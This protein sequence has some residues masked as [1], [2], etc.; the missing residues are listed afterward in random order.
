M[1]PLQ[2]WRASKSATYGFASKSDTHHNTKGHA[3]AC[4]FVLAGVALRNCSAPKGAGCWW[5]N[6]LANFSRNGLPLLRSSPPEDRGAR[7][8]E[9][10][11]IETSV[12]GDLPGVPNK[13]VRTGRR[14]RRPLQIK[15]YLQSHR[16]NGV[17]DR[18]GLAKHLKC[19]QSCGIIKPINTAKENKNGN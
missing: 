13:F 11:A 12:G 19:L 9:D 14:G 10:P 18:F 4:P 7:G 1:Y 6:S 2:N 5:E 17:L 8:F 3:H 16:C 15:I